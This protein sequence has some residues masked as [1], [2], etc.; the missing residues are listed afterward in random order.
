MAASVWASFD[1]RHPWLAW[2]WRWGI[3]AWSLALGLLTL[4]VFRRG[5]PRAG[6]I[7]GYLL[8]L[9]C[10]F[11][12]FTELRAALEQRG[13]QLVVDAGEYAMLTL[14]HNLL[15]F[16]LPAYYASATLT[17][18]NAIFPAAVALL[19]LVTAVDPLYRWLVR[20]RAWAHDLLLGFSMF[21][22]LNVAL[23]LVRV[24]PILALEGSAALAVLALTPAL[25][26]GGAVSWRKAHGRAALA[27]CLAMV[28]VWYA[29]AVV[30]PAPL[31]LARSVAARAVTDLT[32][33]DVIDG[34]VPAATVAEWGGLAA[35]TAV[36][37]PGGLQQAIQHVWSK[38]GVPFARIPLSPVRGGR[39]EGFRTFSVTR[40]LTAPFDGRYTVDV[41]TA[42]GQLIGRLRFA[43][44]P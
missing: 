1:G 3:S 38:N 9:W 30:P 15:L 31:F 6:W 39:A 12:V 24:R 14:C 17:S 4:F 13:H 37:A 43:V 36:Y 27:A 42:S 22:A 10:L 23:P 8:L 26:Q 25:R 41:V 28:A 33:I 32:P 19:A 7:V 21:A 34:A 5:L 35:Y 2:L 16:V 11:A 40:N 29:R 44:T 20:G 18:V